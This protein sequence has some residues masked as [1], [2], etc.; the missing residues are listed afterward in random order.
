MNTIRTKGQIIRSHTITYFNILNLIL[1]GLVILSGQFKNMLFMGVVISNALIGIIQELKVKK[2]IDALSVITATKAKLVE[3]DTIREIPIE[4]LAV[5]DVIQV[6]TGDQVVADC[7]VLRS[8]GLEVNESL[9]TGESLPILKKPGD[10]LYSGSHIVA[11]SGQGE[12]I[13]TGTDNYATQLV[14]KARTKKRATSEMQNAIKSIIKYVSYAIIPI[15][16]LL[17]CIQRFRAGENI[18]NAIVNTV[19]GVLGMIPEGLVL[20]TSI[21]FILGVGRL[22]MKKALVQEMEAIE[23]LARVNVLCLDKTGTITTGDLT[24]ENV[25]LCGTE[26]MKHFRSVMNSLVYAFSEGNATS[27]ALQAYFNDE[28][29]YQASDTLPFS[30]QRKYMGITLAEEGSYLLGAPDF[31]TADS[32]LLSQAEEYARQGLRVLL[33]ISSPQ[34]PHTREQLAGILSSTTP[35]GLIL[36][37]DHIKEDAHDIFGFFASQ[38]VDIK[39]ISGDNAATVSSVGVRAGVKGAEQYADA[40]A[41]PEDPSLLQKEVAGYNVFGRVSP[42]MKQAIIRAYQANGCVVGMVGDGVNDV[43]ALKDAD[44]GIAMANGADA[45]RQSAHIV[46]LDSDFSC[47]KNI[48]K[49]GRTIIANIERVSALYLTKTIYSILL[50]IIFIILGKSYPFIPIQLSLIGATA[51]GIPSFLLA[52]E[53]HDEVTTSGFLRHVLR[54]SLPAALTLTAILTAI[55]FAASALSISDAMVS[56]LNLLAGGVISLSVVIRVCLPMTKSRLA[57][58]SGI[59]I[60]FISAFLFLPEF[61]GVL[62]IWQMFR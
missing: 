32:K 29:S 30:S 62:P 53:Q 54:I 50:C 20:L 45:A 5:H 26:S 16:I 3:N 38:G 52:L 36:L 46:L 1:A 4:D 28:N 48:V 47:M 25:I 35:R 60:L 33:L 9:L 55:P 59:T 24:V 31:L 37:S 11:G 14:M 7:T 57:I 51:I 22:A 43:L 27:K 17:F 40:T 10:P 39:I 61:F 13:H 44:C 6:S 19:A 15:G 2:L 23:A 12:I 21:S 41:L 49:E 56:T 34:L 8:D 42:E 58:C 18:S